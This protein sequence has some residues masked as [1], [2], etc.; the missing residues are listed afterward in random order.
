MKVSVITVV[1]NSANTIEDAIRSVATQDYP[2]V[3]HIIVDGASTDGTLDIIKRHTATVTKYISETD[4]GLYDAMNKGLGMATGEVIGFL[5]ADDVYVHSSV[6]S[7][8]AE[9]L[10][11]TSTDACYADLVYVSPDDPSRVVRYWKSR[12]YEEGLFEK[13]WMPAHPTFFASRAIYER[14]GGFDLDFK[15]QAD[16]ELTMR[17][18]AVHKI[19]S[20]YIPEI[21]IRMRTGGVSNSSLS[22]IWQGNLEAYRACK[23]HNLPVTPLFIAKKV[24]SRLPQ[25]FA[26]PHIRSGSGM[27]S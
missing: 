12:P 23:K 27:P 14:L 1:R 5:N 17:F 24:F 4:K 20:V 13:G 11:R 16:F 6:L 2:D 10:R 22:G 25:F 15:R 3:E 26:R 8:V 19:R 7:R 18:L 21:W 9:A